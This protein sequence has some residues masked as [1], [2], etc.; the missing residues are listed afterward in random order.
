M[1]PINAVG[2]RKDNASVLF[3]SS[4][5]KARA[6]AHLSYEQQAEEMYS[7]SVV[8]VCDTSRYHRTYSVQSFPRLDKAVIHI[9]G[10]DSTAAGSITLGQVYGIIFVGFFFAWYT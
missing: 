8:F 2:G 1:G 4:I 6:I 7:C 5:L 10:L 3:V 9:Q